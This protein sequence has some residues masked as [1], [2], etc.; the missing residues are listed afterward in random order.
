MG[1]TTGKS[2]AEPAPAKAANGKA[3][4]IATA[5]VP[6]T[7]AALRVNPG[8]GLTRAEVEIRRKEHGYN[9]VAET[10]GH[11][12]LKFLRKFWGISAWMLELI[13]ILSAALGKYSDLVVV[14]ALLVINAVLSFLQE[15]RAAGVVEALRRR[16][17]VS[18]RVLRDSSWQ[19]VPA[20]EL[21]PGDI[22]RVRPGD[23]IPADVKLLT[24]AL[25]VDQSALTGESK[26]ADKTPGEVLS[27]GSIVRRGE[28]NGV[29]M[30]TVNMTGRAT[31][32]ALISSTSTRGAISRSDSPRISD[33]T[34][35]TASST[36]TMTKSQRTTLLTTASMWS[37][38]R[39]CWTSSMVRPK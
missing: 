34:T 20:R 25:T 9:E 32:T 11:P 36:P 24:E 13:M 39:A 2:E 8:T 26:D 16:L 10:K 37:V 14:S 38:G 29:V 4:D 27:S 33:R 22:V 19:V 35:T 28:G 3:P 31:G 1:T 7:L 15:R 6:D 30:L 17:Q 12:V 5:S 23:I 21:V 18:A